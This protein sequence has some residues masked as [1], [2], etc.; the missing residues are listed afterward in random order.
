M[1]HLRYSRGGFLQPDYSELLTDECDGGM[2][3]SIVSR[4]VLQ[5]YMLNVVLAFPGD[6]LNRL[7]TYPHHSCTS[8]VERELSRRKEFPCPID[9]VAVKRV[10]LSTR[11]LD[12]VMVEKDTSWRRR[13]TKVFNKVEKDFATL[14][15]Y[16]N[17]LEEV[18]DIS[19]FKTSHKRIYF[20][21]LF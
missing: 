18:E 14:L 2:W 11:T 4:Q 21:L 1:R 16:N 3:T 6:E 7:T 9:G 12:D 17:Y 13:V 8:C 15:E 5:F 19:T 10:T 20:M